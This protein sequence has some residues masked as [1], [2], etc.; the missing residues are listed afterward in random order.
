MGREVK[1]EHLIIDIDCITEDDMPNEALKEIYALCGKEV[2]VSLMENQNGIFIMMPAR[3]FKKLEK[4]MMIS[5]FDGSA[6]SLRQLARKYSLS[7]VVIRDI[8][9]KANIKAPALNI[10]EMEKANN[11]F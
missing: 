8:L 1:T 11:Q 6:A 2:A 5:E 7:E 9:K 3:P 10:K 4:R